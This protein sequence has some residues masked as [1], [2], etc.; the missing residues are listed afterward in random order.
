MIDP[1]QVRRRLHDTQKAM[2][3]FAQKG[4]GDLARAAQAVIETCG[5]GGKVLI[6]GNGGSA[7][8]AQ[9]IAAELVN[10]MLKDRDPIP[11]IALT[12]DT[13]I[14]TSVANDY[15]FEAVFE[16]QVRAL[17]RPG[18]LAWGLS[19]SGRSENVIRALRAAGELK[20]K[21]LSMA[22]PPGSDIGDVS[23][24]VIWVEAKST[25]LIQG[26]RHLIRSMTCLSKIQIPLKRMSCIN[27]R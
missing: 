2:E 13:S 23:D 20:M 12:T 11:A 7:S 5:S 16:K 27:T 4:S 19:T 22:G 21:R 6:F 26:I 3:T 17:G 8:Q 24:M 9:H 15:E 18:D 14:I 1:E 10:R 25:P